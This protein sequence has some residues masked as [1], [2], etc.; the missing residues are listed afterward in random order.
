V[1]LKIVDGAYGAMMQRLGSDTNLNLF[2]LNYFPDTWE[3]IN[4]L[5]VPKHFFVDDIVERRKTL[6]PTAKRAGWVG[7][8]I[9]LGRIPRAGKIFIIR[10]KSVV[11]RKEVMKAWE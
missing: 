3:I 10:N 1:G 6:S 4:L 9:L 11:A 2:L 8:N 7:C 5:V